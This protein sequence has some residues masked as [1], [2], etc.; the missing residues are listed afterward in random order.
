MS[1]RPGIA[2][3]IEGVEAVAARRIEWAF[4]LYAV[5]AGLRV[6][7]PERADVVLR[8]GG[9]AEAGDVLL[10]ATYRARLAGSPAPTPSIADPPTRDPSLRP[11]PCFHPI[12]PGGPD[13]LGEIFE[14]VSADH[15]RSITQSDA[16]G[17]LP[18]AETLQGR[19]G[20]SP[21]VP[22]ATEAM[23]WLHARIAAG[24]NRPAN[25]PETLVGPLGRTVVAATHDLDFLPGHAWQ[26]TIRYTKNL[27]Y[28]ARHHRSIVGQVVAAGA[29]AVVG[30]HPLDRLAWMVEREHELGIESSVNILCRQAHPRDANYALSEARTQRRLE[31]LV[32]EGVE[33][34]LHGSYTSLQGQGRLE[35][36]Y[37]ALRRLGY[38]A[39]GGRQH[40]LR[41]R[42][43]RLFTE[44]ERSGALYDSSA[45]FADQPGFRHG[46]SFPFPPWDFEREQPFP[47]LEIPLA[48]MEAALEAHGDAPAV[49][50]TVLANAVSGG[51]GGIAVLW[52]DPVFGGTQCDRRVADVYWDL[53]RP[54]QEWLSPRELT[55]A[56][57]SAYADCG[58]LPREKPEPSRAA[59]APGRVPTPAL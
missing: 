53:K 58:V 34:G 9:R 19:Y 50:H 24:A 39:R 18:F 2:V 46:A 29:G 48:V 25:W 42:D 52:H 59:T 45:G 32:D 14:W 35:H 5:V 57:W 15:E 23:R 54:G 22:W 13:L 10:S 28:A 3:R 33:V 51:W 49:A 38:V 56:V 17:R 55:L 26:T 16:V 41:Y 8:Y 30:R 47:L 7:E 21:L 4:R 37:V 40:W 1:A 43:N 31:W 12:A 20:L 36:E 11:L 44:L 27:A 6:T